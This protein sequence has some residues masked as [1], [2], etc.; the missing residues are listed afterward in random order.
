MLLWGKSD[1]CH[2]ASTVMGC[3]QLVARF[4][5]IHPGQSTLAFYT[6]QNMSNK[7]ITG[8][9]TYNVTPQS[10]GSYFNKIQCFCFEVSEANSCWEGQQPPPCSD[11]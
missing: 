9:S 8:V 4:L 10:A 3:K 11:Q 6:A 1:S 7:A 5:Q 2:P